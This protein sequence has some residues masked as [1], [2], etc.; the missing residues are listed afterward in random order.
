MN[1]A[2]EIAKV[3]AQAAK[4]G[5]AFIMRPDAEQDEMHK[6]VLFVAEFDGKEELFD[7]FF[8]TLEEEFFA[9]IFEDAVQ[10][11]IQQ[12]PEYAEMDFNAEEGPHLELMDGIVD[13]L[14][15]DED[16]QVSEFYE[17]DEFAAEIGV[18]LDVCLNREEITEKDIADFIEKFK[19]NGGEVEL[20]DTRRSFDFE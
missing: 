17:M 14:A 19:K 4:E 15:K 6:N 5:R 20:D 9:N 7:A 13:A 16:Y 10:E 3:K 8:Y 12:K 2:E 18:G 1:H 11:V